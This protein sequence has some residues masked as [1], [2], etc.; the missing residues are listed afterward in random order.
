[1]RAL[2]DLRHLEFLWGSQQ[3]RYYSGARFSAGL[4]Y[5]VVTIP[6][7]HVVTKIEKK[8]AQGERL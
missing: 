6:L 4:F 5:L 1:M 2:S 7:I 3:R 8:M